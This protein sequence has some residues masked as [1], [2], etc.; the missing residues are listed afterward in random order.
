MSLQSLSTLVFRQ[1]FSLNLQLVGHFTASLKDSPV[2]FP[3][4]P[5]PR[6]GIVSTQFCTDIGLSL[7][8]LNF[9]DY[10]SYRTG[11]RRWMFQ[12]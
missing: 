9:Q 4:P 12:G 10:P 7:F 1:G 11:P 3:P 8:K 5:P 6:A 2:R